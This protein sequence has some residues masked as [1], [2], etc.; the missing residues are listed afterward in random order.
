[1]TDLDAERASVD[2]RGRPGDD[3]ALRALALDAIL[4]DAHP[5]KMRAAEF[6]RTH[7]VDP[8]L[9]ERDQSCTFWD[10]GWRRL[11]DAGMIGLLVDPELGGQGLDLCSTLLTIEGLG[12][13][14]RD[15]GLTF[16]L[17]AQVLTMQLTLQRF[18]TEAQQSHWLPQLVNGTA[19]GS[20][21]MSEPGSGSDAYS[22]VTTAKRAADGGYHIDGEKAWV[23]M[24]P[25]ADVFIVFAS[26]NPDVGRWGIS[27]FV[28]PA[29]TPGVLVGDNRPKMGMRTT[30][31]S[32]VTFDGCVVPDSARIGNEGSGAGI[33]S[34]AMEAERAFLLA[35]AIGNLER[36][37]D[38]T[39]AYAKQRKQFGEAIGSF[40][41]VSHS[42][43]EVK[44]G[45][46]SARTL[47]YKAAALQQLGKPSMLAAAIAKLVVSEE[48]LAG[49][50]AAVEVH[51]APGY[52]TE[53]GVERDV[54]NTVGGIIYGGS[55]GIQ[56]NI[57]ARLLG[58]PGREKT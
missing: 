28:V 55:S 39:V 1:M 47:L 58:L 43:A 18:G 42:I 36:T 2:V 26:T 25:K 52:V 10:E 12:L 46:E 49:A 7:L 48:S 44:V 3:A 32:T 38:D 23:T 33:F 50:L 37:L 53:Y 5:V 14:C 41:G 17:S 4:D 45:L 22:L 35:G 31:F 11:A 24:G 19:F 29:D 8:N 56:K 27:T 16:A 9:I 20:F 34:A 40:Q 6:A 51:G 13:G 21:C 54:R 30:P 15:D 57:I